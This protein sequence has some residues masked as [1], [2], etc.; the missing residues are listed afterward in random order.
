M[1]EEEDDSQKLVTKPFK[2]VTGEL[3]AWKIID[4]AADIETLAGMSLSFSKIN[5]PLVDLCT[6]H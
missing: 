4:V 3:F 1:S 5:Q 6:L 2:F